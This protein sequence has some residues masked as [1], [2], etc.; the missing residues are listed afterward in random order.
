MKL[1]LL[2]IFSSLASYLNPDTS[3]SYP[4]ASTTLFSFSA[5]QSSLILLTVSDFVSITMLNLQFSP[6]FSY[7]LQSR[8]KYFPVSIQA[9]DYIYIAL[10][11]QYQGDVVP[12]LGSNPSPVINSTQGL[13]LIMTMQGQVARSQF[14]GS[15]DG[16]DRFIIDLYV[17]T[18]VYALYAE[19]CSS[20]VCVTGINGEAPQCWSYYNKTQFSLKGS[21]NNV[22]LALIGKYTSEIYNLNTSKLVYSFQGAIQDFVVSDSISVFSNSQLFI[23]NYNG[24]ITA[25]TYVPTPS[26]LLGVYNNYIVLA[27][28]TASS[29][30]DFTPIYNQAILM[31]AYNKDL[32]IE[33]YRGLQFADPLVAFT[34][35]SQGAYIALPKSLILSENIF[36]MNSIKNCANVSTN[37]INEARCSNCI[38]GYSLLANHCL[39]SLNC[40]SGYPDLYHLACSNCS[41]GCNNCSS[42]LPSDCIEC[43]PSYVQ[44]QNQCLPNCPISYYQTLGSCTKCPSKC[45]ACNESSCLSCNN[46]F[47]F[48]GSCIDSCP[49]RTYESSN[50]CVA[51]EENCL[52]CSETVCFVCS[53]GLFPNNTK[54][55]QCQNGC[56][57]C[58]VTGCSVCQTGL[59]LD[60]GSCYNCSNCKQCRKG[61]CNACYEGF[62]LNSTNKQCQECPAGCDECN[63]NGCLSCNLSYVLD[64]SVCRPCPGFVNQTGCHSCLDN[65]ATCNETS[66]FSC[67]DGYFIKDKTCQACQTDCGVCNSTQCIECTKGALYNGSCVEQCP[68]GFE[69][70]ENMCLECPL[71]CAECSNGECSKCAADFIENANFVLENGT[72]IGKQCL[73]GFTMVDQVCVAGWSTELEQILAL[74]QSYFSLS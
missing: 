16:F 29:I 8:N 27:F 60:S 13:I 59:V 37:L 24:L 43:E 12:G 2:C 56:L 33:S 39:P 25:Q 5:T 36:A 57:S 53:N 41:P 1:Y 58:S 46:S 68:E 6:L 18:R 31:I 51:C 17:A 50:Q 48:N 47:L 71:N 42:P 15:C 11:V 49:T 32:E 44:F 21:K 63:E 30:F 66:C 70:I 14:L 4:L 26:A 20:Q 40:H 61:N 74:L 28:S 19:I 72:C 55:S 54:C 38:P 35:A 52:N 7:N 23:L 45:N 69:E 34:F 64:Q 73:A 22:F 65:C 62:F 67:Q 3:Q 9:S 10:N